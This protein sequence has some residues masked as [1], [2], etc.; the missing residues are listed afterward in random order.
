[1]D[2]L[3]M[4]T[5]VEAKKETD[6]A[7]KELVKQ[8]R[9]NCGIFFVAFVLTTIA[10][11]IFIHIS[12]DPSLNIAM[13]YV[14]G[15]FIVARYTEGYI[16][17]FLFSVTSVVSVNYFFTYPYG[18]LNFVIEG[19][20]ITFAAML[21][22][23]I[24][25][26]AMTTHMKEQAR[27]LMEQEK[28][29]MMAQKEKMRANLLRAVSHDLRTPLTGIIGTSESVL[30]MKDSLSEEEE[31]KMISNIHDDANWL[32]GMVENLLSITR[33]DNE[34]TK[35]NKSL[36]SV[37]EVVEASAIRF[38]KRFPNAVVKVTLPEDVVMVRMDVMLIEQVLINILQNAEVHAHPKK[39]HEIIVEER[40]NDVLFRV[41]DYGDGIDKNK[42]RTI[43]D[44][45][46]YKDDPRESDSYKGMGIGLSICKTIVLAHGGNIQAVN[47]SEGAE[48]RFSLPKEMGE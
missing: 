16:F 3:D 2:N 27:I 1:M 13:F 34:T 12:A 19:Y 42:L 17:G 15:L 21:A 5:T 14:L 8:H 24:T 38:R 7:I 23:A 29:L 6:K 22:I 18:N 20:Q 35:V 45:E 32:L 33:I 43:F 4:K 9:R 31:L 41:R 36:E 30:E 47:H 44:G 40:E 11:Y 48:F 25:T 28:E 26:S 10:S 46:G 37:D 39:P